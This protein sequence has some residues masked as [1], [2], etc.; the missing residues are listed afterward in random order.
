MTTPIYSGTALPIP[1][2][3]SLLELAGRA[4]TNL[5]LIPGQRNTQ[6][7]WSPYVRAADGKQ[8]ALASDVDLQVMWLQA[9]KPINNPPLVYWRIEYGHG[10]NVYGLP[11][12][13]ALSGPSVTP[14]FNTQADGG[15]LLPNRGLRLRLPTRDCRVHF[16]TPAEAEPPPE[17][18]VPGGAP[19]TLQVSV[20]PCFGLGAQQLPVTDGMFAQVVSP[21]LIGTPAQLPLG[22]SEMRLCDPT[23]GQA[24]AAGEQV[25]FYDVTG[26]P[27]A[28]GPQAMALFALWTPIPIFAAFWAAGELAQVSYR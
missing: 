28:A 5:E 1:A 16:F 6:Y 7:S 25:A 18:V 19:C 14:E 17:P 26:A 4:G 21:A 27:M 8:R 23:T 9:T 10:E 20:Q 13:S 11:M 12:R 22:A 3:Q 2:S 24:F 15:W